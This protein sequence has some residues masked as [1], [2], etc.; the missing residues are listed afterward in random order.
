MSVESIIMPML[1]AP[2]FA[3]LDPQRIKM[4]ALS[5]ERVAFA[6]GEFLVREDE[7]GMCAY[8][9]CSGKVVCLEG[10]DPALVH[11][12]LGPG[13]L[14]GGLAMLVETTHLATVMARTAVSALSFPRA[15]MYDLMRQDT[16]LAQYFADKLRSRLVAMDPELKADEPS[17]QRPHLPFQPSPAELNPA[18]S[19]R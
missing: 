13:T 10:P 4:L 7:P 2:L 8:L 1:S 18:R 3:D 19:G 17:P 12:E 11:V 9:V 15:T 5:A 14:I 6:P 16:G